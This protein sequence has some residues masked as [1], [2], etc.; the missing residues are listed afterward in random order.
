MFGEDDASAAILMNDAE[1]VLSAGTDLEI[2]SG[3]LGR[4]IRV[5]EAYITLTTHSCTTS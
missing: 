3:S 2:T 4:I 5:Y 1:R